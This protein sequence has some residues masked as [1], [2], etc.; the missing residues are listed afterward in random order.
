MP[1]ARSHRSNRGLVGQA[2]QARLEIFPGFEH[3][4]DILLITYVYV[5][6][7]RKDREKD[8]EYATLWLVTP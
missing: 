2:R 6:K 8:M 3:L 4:M 7:L 1:V 5:E